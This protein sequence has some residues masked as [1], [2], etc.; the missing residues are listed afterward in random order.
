M[1]ALHAAN[2]QT[3]TM[4]HCLA[5]NKSRIMM[6][7]SSWTHVF[8]ITEQPYLNQ[9]LSDV[10][11]PKGTLGG[12]WL[13]ALPLRVAFAGNNQSDCSSEIKP[14]ILTLVKCRSNDFFLYRC[15]LSWKL[16]IP[17]H[18]QKTIL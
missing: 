14:F 17:N 7:L 13:I 10:A 1:E 3:F 18:I 4:L 2:Q 6:S 5:K 15:F 9:F 8:R 16:T 12:N 11:D